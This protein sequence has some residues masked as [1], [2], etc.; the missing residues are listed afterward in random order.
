MQKRKRIVVATLC[1][2]LFGFVCLGIASSSPGALAWPVAV[3]I[4]VSRTLIGFAIGISCISLRHWAI[5][6]LFMGL[7]FSLPLA[8]SG[9]MAPESAEFSKIGMLLWTI[10]LGMV[11]GLLIEVI[12]SVLFKAK[13][14][15]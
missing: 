5:H 13:H 1:G 14:Q 4:I 15:G 2:V 3:Q 9:L 10:I 8:F 11:Y 12:T 6:G 7:I